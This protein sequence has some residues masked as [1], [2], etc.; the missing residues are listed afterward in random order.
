MDDL[1]RQERALRGQPGADRV[2]LLRWLKSGQERSLARAATTLGYSE[3]HVQR[4]WQRYVAGGL[5]GLVHL[6]QRGGRRE[7]ITADAWAGLTEQMRAGQIRRL[8]D[9][10]TYLQEQW[11]LHYC[12]DALSKLFQRRKTKLKTGR[13]RHRRADAAA[14]AAFKKGVRSN[15]GDAQPAPGVR[16]G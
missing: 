12:L 9:A 3:R 5:A 4:W 8:K 13:P 11:G 16:P 15:A 14:Q 10:Q 6:R 1:L 2:K 7:R